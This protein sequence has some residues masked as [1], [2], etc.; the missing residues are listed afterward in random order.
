MAVVLQPD[1]VVS[2]AV[3]KTRTSAGF[4]VDLTFANWE[5][6]L[7]EQVYALFLGETIRPDSLVR[8]AKMSDTLQFVVVS[9]DGL[10]AMLLESFAV[11]TT[12]SQEVIIVVTI[13]ERR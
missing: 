3:A 2:N 4:I 7:S 12:N 10:A 5:G 11:I 6:R 9:R 8:S 1:V 13:E